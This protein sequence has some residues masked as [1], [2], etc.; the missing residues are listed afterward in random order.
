MTLLFQVSDLSNSMRQ[1]NSNLHH[2]IDRSNEQ[3]I[4]FFSL[5]SPHT[6]S[7]TEKLIIYRTDSPFTGYPFPVF[8]RAVPSP[9]LPGRGIRLH[10]PISQPLG[11]QVRVLCTD[12]WSCSSFWALPGSAEARMW[13]FWLRS[14]KQGSSQHGV[15][16]IDLL[17]IGCLSG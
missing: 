5:C 14:E 17:W 6:L 1:R 2:L 12:S 16:L 9:Y 7:H 8:V 10:N 13:A 3:I 11:D 4:A 15:C